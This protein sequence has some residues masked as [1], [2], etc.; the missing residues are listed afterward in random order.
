MKLQQLKHAAYRAW[1]FMQSLEEI[2]VQP[3]IFK[4]EARKYG[5][6][7]RRSTWEK[8]YTVFQAAVIANPV[9]EN[10]GMIQ[11]YFCHATSPE[12]VEYNDQV[13]EEYLKYPGALER[14]RDGL[15]QLYYQP[16]E[17]QDQVDAVNFLKRLSGYVET[18]PTVGALPDSL[19]AIPSLQLAGR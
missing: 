3:E 9:L 17:P 4:Q 1:E 15:D 7:R 6:L 12:L 19:T 8:V 16:T 10:C 13:L 14:I 18:A 5:D 2:T 11:V